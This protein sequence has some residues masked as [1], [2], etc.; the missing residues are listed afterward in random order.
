MD[1]LELNYFGLLRSPVSWAKVGREIILGLIKRNIKTHIYE[2]KGFRYNKSF[3]LD[4]ELEESISNKFISDDTL[5]FEYPLNYKLIK[6]SKRY[7]MLV[8]ETTVLPSEWADNIN[9][10]LD[11][12]FVPSVFN[13]EIFLAA[14]VKPEIIRV[15]PHGINQEYY[16]KTPLQERNTSNIFRFLTIAMPQK[17]KGL[18][19]LLAAFLEAFKDKKDVEL[20]AKLSYSPG[21]SKYDDIVIEKYKKHKNIRFIIAEYTE[22]Q[23]GKLYRSAKCFVLP[24]RAEGFGMVYLEA[25][26][27]GIPVIATGWG[28]HTDFLNEANSELLKYKLV[29]AGLVQYDNNSK[30]AVMSEPDFN[31]LVVKLVSVYNN[32]EQAMGKAGKF[33]IKNFYWQ[34]IAKKLKKY[35]EE[36]R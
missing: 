34:N 21:K 17:R 19:I 13:K 26:A 1:K 30:N 10:Y 35:I 6:S 9:K 8:Y 23:M 7:G 33:Q 31:D 18:D 28:G 15:L 25:L 32:Y 12:L 16:F 14:G 3:K 27:C 29:A 11:L 4:K 20:I 2:R 36:Q 24:S 5:T 22:E